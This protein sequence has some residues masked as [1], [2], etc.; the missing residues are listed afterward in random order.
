M[1]LKLKLTVHLIPH[2][3][4]FPRHAI[5]HPK[6]VRINQHSWRPAERKAA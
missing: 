4:P 2:R 6:V 1:H 5:R 3:R